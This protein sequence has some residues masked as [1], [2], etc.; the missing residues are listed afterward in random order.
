MEA[1]TARDVIAE[2]PRAASPSGA[3]G[4]GSQDGSSTAAA[5]FMPAAGANA[6]PAFS[7]SSLASASG[8]S[9]PKWLLVIFHARDAHSLRCAL[10]CKRAASTIV[11]G[12]A[13]S[14]GPPLLKSTASCSGEVWRVSKLPDGC[15]GKS[16]DAFSVPATTQDG[17]TVRKSACTQ[18]RPHAHLLHTMALYTWTWGRKE[19]A[20]D[21]QMARG[22]GHIDL[23]RN[24]LIVFAA[25]NRQGGARHFADDWQCNALIGRLHKCHTRLSKPTGQ[26]DRS[27]WRASRPHLARVLSC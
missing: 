12:A 2:A 11:L 10:S 19:R 9:R 6:A 1:G 21:A 18:Q 22:K 17:I 5:P 27:F 8:P 23:L 13:A 15:L 20:S 7:R 4:A 24:A 26:T 14:G 25:C 16:L 3:A